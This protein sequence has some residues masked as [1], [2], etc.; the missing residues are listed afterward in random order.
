M[1]G[2]L[3][4]LAT[5][6]L[7]CLLLLPLA[8]FSGCSGNT[9]VTVLMATD[10][11]AVKTLTQEVTDKANVAVAD[12][13]SLTVTVN[14]LVLDQTDGG[15]VELVVTPQDVD[16]IDLAGVSGLLTIAEVSAGTYTK[17]RLGIENPRL[18]LKA[19]PATELTD[20]HLTAN[21]HM[22]VD[23]QFALPPNTNTNIL[24]TFNGLHLVQQGNGG[25]TLTPQL[26]AQ[27]SVEL[28]PVSNQG[29]V[30]SV[31][32][33]AGTMVLTIGDADMTV[34]IADAAIYLPGDTDTPTGTAADLTVG[35]VVAVEGS[36]DADGVIVAARLTVQP[37]E[38]TA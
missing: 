4:T 16:L 35:T 6:G 32:A 15:Q 12:I 2:K 8:V 28:V 33:A 14:S 30:V 5:L 1:S 11:N 21:A 36:V 23:V 13:A 17:I 22:F 27:V 25:F 38:P 34:N 9:K 31:D 7:I 3:R 24:L 26:R 10:V 37:P 18:V 20:I 29:T 19:D